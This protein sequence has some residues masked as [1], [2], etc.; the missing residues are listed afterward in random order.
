M[1]NRKRPI[2]PLYMNAK[3]I[4]LIE[5]CPMSTAQR[6][7]TQL[8]KEEGLVKK[9]K[10][11]IGAYCRRMKVSIEEVAPYYLRLLIA[12]TT[13][14]IAFAFGKMLLQ[15]SCKYF[16]EHE[17]HW[18]ERTPTSLKG[19][20]FE[21]NPQTKKMEKVSFEINKIKT[22]PLN[23]MKPTNLLSLALL[24]LAGCKNQPAPAPVPVKFVE[25]KIIIIPPI[26]DSF[27]VHNRL[28]VS[29]PYR[30][31]IGHS[32]T[33]MFP[34]SMHLTGENYMELLADTT[35]VHIKGDSCWLEYK[36]AAVI[37]AKRK[38]G[39]YLDMPTSAEETTDTVKVR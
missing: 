35:R 39:S 29:F 34:D 32:V 6:R 15:Y 17:I 26:K 25:E 13:I 22:I 8:K 7:L 12:A 27:S 18:E 4:A 16:R 21:Y 5:D 1:E 31:K 38:D 37:H 20:T 24:C 23:F 2:I 10:L 36:T 28:H 3:D 33:D 9:D 11:T 30:Y 14:T 19:H